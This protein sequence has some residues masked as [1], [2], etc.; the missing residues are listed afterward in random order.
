MSVTPNLIILLG[1]PGSGRSTQSDRLNLEL[2]FPVI[3]I[4]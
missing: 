2:A 4:R 3:N 1:L